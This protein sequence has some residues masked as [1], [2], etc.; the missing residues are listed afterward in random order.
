MEVRRNSM[1]Y[2]AGKVYETLYKVDHVSEIDEILLRDPRFDVALMSK[3][4][5]ISYASVDDLKV[6]FKKGFFEYDDHYFYIETIELEKLKKVRYLVIRGKTIDE[7][8]AQARHVMYGVLLFSIF[9]F[10]VLIFALS[11][12]FLKPLREYIQRLDQFI[13]DATHELNT[14]ISVLSMSLERIDRTGMDAKNTKAVDRMVVAVRTLSH[15]YDDLTFVMFPQQKDF[16][17]TLRIDELV[18]QRVAYFEPIAHAKRVSIATHV[19]PSFIVANE[20]HIIR[21]IDNLLSNGIKYNKTGGTID[22]VVQANMMKISDTGIGFDQSEADSIFVRYKRLD[23]ANGGFG[24]GL[25]IVETICNDYG[26]SISVQ[27]AINSGSQFSLSWES[28][29]RSS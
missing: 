28:E 8:L 4:Q 7:E 5:M 2:Y 1:I 26:I 12:L 24:L 14:P 15:L 16:I 29:E 3:R 25:N 23:S 22:I 6:P 13:R 11:K 17:T 19:E 20:R 10:G 18:Q 9:F 21:V 27:S